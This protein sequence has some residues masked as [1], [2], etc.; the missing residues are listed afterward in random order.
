MFSE[1]HPTQK[2]GVGKSL[3]Y[4]VVSLLHEFDKPSVLPISWSKR[5]A[6]Y[7]KLFF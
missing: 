4:F 2:N 7:I 1:I 5:Y 3:I 6:L